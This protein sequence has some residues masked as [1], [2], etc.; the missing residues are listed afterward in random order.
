MAVADRPAASL[1]A[2]IRSFLACTATASAAWVVPFTVPG[3]NPVTAAAL[4]GEIPRSPVM[5]VGPV[6][7]TA[8]PARTANGSAVPSATGVV[9]A[10]F[11]VR[12]AA[13]L[14]AQH[15]VFDYERKTRGG[16]YKLCVSEITV[17]GRMRD[18]ARSRSP[19]RHIKGIEILI[20][21][22]PIVRKVYSI[23]LPNT[24]NIPA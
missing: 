10:A 8:V 6:F 15:A 19:L 7:V 9:P 21:G 23:R 22:Y 17:P 14:D 13:S 3:G 20:E 11:A 16:R 24:P 2:V 12:P 1:Y 18:P 5:V 4:P